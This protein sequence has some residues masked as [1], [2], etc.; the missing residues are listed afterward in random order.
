MSKSQ[1]PN[2]KIKQTLQQLR[3]SSSIH[4][5]DSEQIRLRA[6]QHDIEEII[7]GIEKNQVANR[8]LRALKDY[9]APTFDGNVVK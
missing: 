4:I 3:E 9:M 7:M 6:E 5:D 1:K 8:P 2:L